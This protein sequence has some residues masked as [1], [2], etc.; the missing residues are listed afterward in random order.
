MVATWSPQTLV[1]EG[2][3]RNF[4]NDYRTVEVL[5]VDPDLG[6]GQDGVQDGS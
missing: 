5:P 2:Y 3:G 6:E 4:Y 1:A